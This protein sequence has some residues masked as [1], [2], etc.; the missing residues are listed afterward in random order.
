MLIESTGSCD[1]FEHGSVLGLQVAGG[2]AEYYIRVRLGLC[3]N[4]VPEILS[5][6][7]VSLLE[8]PRPVVIVAKEVQPSP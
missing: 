6:V 7:W 4:I 1:L 3:V 2:P 5:Q 8:V